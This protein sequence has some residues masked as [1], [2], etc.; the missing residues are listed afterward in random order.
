MCCVLPC[1][2]SCEECR[3]VQHRWKAGRE[4]SVARRKFASH[5]APSMQAITH[6]NNKHAKREKSRDE[7]LQHNPRDVDTS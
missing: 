6:R 3:S 4:G 2:C 5:H 7:S 1:L